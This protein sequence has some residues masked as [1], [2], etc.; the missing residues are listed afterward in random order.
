MADSFASRL[1]IESPMTVVRSQNVIRGLERDSF[2]GL[3]NSSMVCN[4]VS[5]G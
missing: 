4:Y 5:I 1:R 3:L 2:C